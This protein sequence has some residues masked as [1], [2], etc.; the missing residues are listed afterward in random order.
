MKQTRDLSWANPGNAVRGVCRENK[1]RNLNIYY[2]SVRKS[3]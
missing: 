3:I 2:K 1:P